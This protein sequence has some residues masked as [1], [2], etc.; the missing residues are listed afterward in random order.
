MITAGI[1][2]GAK[3][4]R[5]VV[6]GEGKMLS[7]SVTPA[8]VDTSTA[9]EKAYDAA[10]ESAGVSRDEVEKVLA[11]GAGKSEPAF[12]AG[13]ITEVRAD[14]RGIHFLNPEVRTVI[15]VG[16]EEGRAIKIDALGK[17]VDFAINERCAAG[18]GAFTEAMARALELPLEEIGPLSLESTEAIALSAQCTVFAETEVVALVH[19]KTAKPDVARAIHDSIAER[20]TSM[21]RRVGIEGKVALIGGLAKNVGF[22]KSLEED[23]D[24]E[25]VLVGEVEYVGALGAALVA[26]DE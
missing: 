19:S 7:K 18:A 14:A 24:T 26:S 9:A 12:K 16:A 8:G 25:I 20:I 10:L 1:D 4:V 22:L 13:V 3:N 21:A 11:T 17:V 15:D 6:F 2:C 23:L 5:V